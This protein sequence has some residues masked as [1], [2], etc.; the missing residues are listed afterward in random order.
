MAKEAQGV[1]WDLT[2]YFPVFNGP[3]MNRFKARLREDLA[4]LQSK[5]A[6]LPPLAPDSE[7]S[8]EQLLGDSGAIV[9]K[10]HGKHRPLSLSGLALDGEWTDGES[11]IS[12]DGIPGGGSNPSIMA[13][14][15][16]SS[17]K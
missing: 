13:Y 16:V 4:A 5:A 1:R 17:T 3:D 15:A 14:S 12:G 10:A 7:D 8:W 6:D 2:S 9:S 11:T